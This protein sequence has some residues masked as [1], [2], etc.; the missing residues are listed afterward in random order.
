MRYAHAFGLAAT[1]VAPG[2]SS[3]LVRPP[4][5]SGNAHRDTWV[6]KRILVAF[7]A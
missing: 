2:K 4:G 3:G 7:G 5:K 6:L 1:A